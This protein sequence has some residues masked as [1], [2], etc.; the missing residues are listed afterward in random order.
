MSVLDVQHVQKIYSSL[1]KAGQ[2]EALKISF[3]SGKG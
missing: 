2:V 1:F 3:C